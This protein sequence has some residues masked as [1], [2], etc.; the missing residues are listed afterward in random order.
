MS[1][2]LIGLL[3]GTILVP[4]GFY[5]YLLSGDAPIA[6]WAKP[7]PMERF[8]V[9]TAMHA[10]IDRQETPI[11]LGNVSD[12]SLVAGAHIYR[13]DCAF[14]HGLPGRAP[15]GPAEGMFPPPPQFFRP[16]AEK[17]DDPAGEVYWKVKNGLRLTGMP[18]F[19]AS[20]SDTQ[21]RELTGFLEDATTLPPAAMAVLKTS[22][23]KTQEPS[24]PT[25]RHAV[26]KHRR[27]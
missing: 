12:G 9:K 5:L 3:I 11:H 14:C 18:A 19:R 4:A 7:M 23:A 13:Q 21:I 6:T 8:L 24:S 10:T 22:R 27:A 1:K 16:N 26:L 15:T 17:I 25:V 2:F 20:L